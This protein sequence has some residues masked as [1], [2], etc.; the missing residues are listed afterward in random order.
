MPNKIYRALYMRDF[1][2]STHAWEVYTIFYFQHSVT[3][4]A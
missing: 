4:H 2:G 3:I 1:Y